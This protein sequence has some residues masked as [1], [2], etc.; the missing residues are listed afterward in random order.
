MDK[1][2]AAMLGELKIRGGDL[3]ILYKTDKVEELRV[4]AAL[5][6]VKHDTILYYTDQA[7]QQ[8]IYIDIAA[9]IAVR[10]TP[11]TAPPAIRPAAGAAPVRPARGF[12]R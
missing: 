9:V 4:D 7:Q 6:D 12:E 2:G 10:F 5:I 1:N 3:V 11:R 8:E